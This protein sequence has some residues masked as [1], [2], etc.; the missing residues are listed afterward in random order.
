MQL[1]PFFTSALEFL[2]SVSIF[3]YKDR[4][5][6]AMI[7]SPMI[8]ATPLSICRCCNRAQVGFA[9]SGCTSPTVKSN[10]E[11]KYESARKVD[12]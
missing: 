6:I 5:R 8:P 1:H 7:M 12:Q 2:Y 9:E 11:E 10:I 4:K 3:V